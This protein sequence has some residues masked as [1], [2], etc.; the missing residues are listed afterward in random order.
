M[1]DWVL[2]APWPYSGQ[3]WYNHR[4]TYMRVLKTLENP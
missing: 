1:F 2:N 3:S 4:V